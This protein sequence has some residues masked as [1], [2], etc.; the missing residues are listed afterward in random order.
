MKEEFLDYLYSIQVNQASS[1]PL[2]NRVVGI[3]LLTG[4]SLCLLYSD[5]L[6]VWFTVKGKPFFL[7]HTYHLYWS[8]CRVQHL[9]VKCVWQHSVT[10]IIKWQITK[11]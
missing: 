3:I 10:H 5:P 6:W 1:D 4:L 11:M 2:L 7:L 8:V 9:H